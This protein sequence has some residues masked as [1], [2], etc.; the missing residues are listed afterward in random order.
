M[1]WSNSFRATPMAAKPPEWPDLD[2]DLRNLA[3]ASISQ[4]KPG[5][6]VELHAHSCFSFLEGASFPDELVLTARLHGYPALALTDHD[7]LH[8]AM[9]FARI[10]HENDLKPITGA[11]LT[12]EGGHHLTLLAETLE[13]YHNL[14]R[15]VSYAHMAN[16][17]GCPITS[18][19]AIRQHSSGLIALS[20]CKQGEVPG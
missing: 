15:L 2:P 12:L 16:E 3:A 11:E 4:S 20:G 1:T 19:D 18:L 5:E 17:R 13:G 9:E 8:G 14:C 6:Y 10:A 7:G